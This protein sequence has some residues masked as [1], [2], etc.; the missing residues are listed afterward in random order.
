[1]IIELSSLA[2][3]HNFKV[4]KFR[5]YKFRMDGAAL[6][7]K[8]SNNSDGKATT[9]LPGKVEKIIPPKLGQPEKAEIAIEGAEHLYK[10][11]R[12]E[13]KLQ[14][15]DGKDVKLKKGAEVEVTVGAE[16]ASTTPK[17]SEKQAQEIEEQN[18]GPFSWPTD[19]PG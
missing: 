7:S 18:K 14:D 9:T 5:F 11:I 2:A 1:M 12:I 17:E 3:I 16:Q 4:G 10:E 13:N 19:M 8:E 15:G 6:M